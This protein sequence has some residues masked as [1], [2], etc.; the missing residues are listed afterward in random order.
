M[1]STGGTIGWKKKKTNNQNDACM[2][3]QGKWAINPGPIKT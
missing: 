1:I 3:S 2:K